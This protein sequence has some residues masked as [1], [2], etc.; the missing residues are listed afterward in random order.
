MDASILTSQYYQLRDKILFDVKEHI[1]K[2]SN[3]K[4]LFG[5]MFFHTNINNPD[6]S[7]SVYGLDKGVLLFDSVYDGFNLYVEDLSIEEL[8]HIRNEIDYYEKNRS[9]SKNLSN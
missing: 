4:L 2:F 6:V 3:E 9:I 1:N 8:L 7:F 5:N